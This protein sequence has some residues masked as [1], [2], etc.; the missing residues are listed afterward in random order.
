MLEYKIVIGTDRVYNYMCAAVFAVVIVNDSS[1]QSKRRKKPN[2]NE[3]KDVSDEIV[4]KYLSTG[5][6][7]VIC[8]VLTGWMTWFGRPDYLFTSHTAY[9]FPTKWCTCSLNGVFKHCQRLRLKWCVQT[10]SV[11][12]VTMVRSHTPSGWHWNGVLKHSQWLTL[13]GVFKHSQCLTLKWYVQKL[14]VADTKMVYS[15]TFS[16]WH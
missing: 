16:G 1:F 5:S 10:L 13:N 14:S 2:G 7:T 11:A 3:K 9:T 4:T 12:D 8:A 6:S 15:N